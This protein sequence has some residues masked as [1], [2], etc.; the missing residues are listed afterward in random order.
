MNTPDIP[1]HSTTSRETRSAMFAMSSSCLKCNKPFNPFAASAAPDGM[2]VGHVV[3]SSK[4][5]I[6]HLSNYQPL[7]T[8]CNTSK[9]NRSNADYRTDAMR[10]EHPK[11]AELVRR[12]E[13]AR[14]KQAAEREQAARVA[15]E[16]VRVATEAQRQAA[17][18]QAAERAAAEAFYNSPDQ[19]RSR[20]AAEAEEYFIQADRQADKASRR[21]R[22]LVVYAILAAVVS[23][24]IIS[25]IGD[26]S[27]EMLDCRRRVE[28]Q[29]RLTGTTYAS[30]NFSICSGL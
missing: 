24:F 17:A 25:D 29:G 11:P 1:T 27:D 20:A 9:G 2:H 10:A 19:R 5:G 4:G 26:Y 12:Q 8:R 6:D 15:T 3:P 30:L 18:R 16:A 23:A 13:E 21:R 14:R 7:C 28:A 22:T